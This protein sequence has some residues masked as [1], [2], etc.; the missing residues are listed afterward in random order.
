MSNEFE[1]WDHLGLPARYESTHPTIS[2]STLGFVD[3]R[4]EEGELLWPDRIDDRTLTNLEKSLGSYG[5]AGQL[6]Q[7]PM[8]RGGGLLKAEWWSEWEDD[9]LPNI[10]YLIQS[11]DTAYSQN[12]HTVN[13][14][15]PPGV[16][17]E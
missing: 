13:Q 5:S 9:E 16:Y 3:P 10:E 12:K 8:P 17:L 1:D 6:Q 4:K 11:Y 7:R 14:Q 2:R 15:G